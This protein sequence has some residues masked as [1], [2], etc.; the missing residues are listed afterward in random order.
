[1]EPLNPWTAIRKSMDALS[2]IAEAAAT[3]AIQPPAK[4]PHGHQ[5]SRHAF[6]EL[7]RGSRPPLVEFNEDLWLG[8]DRYGEEAGPMRGPAR[9]EAA[10]Y[11]AAAAG[12]NSTSGAAAIGSDEI[13]PLHPTP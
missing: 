2:V 3:E 4:R 6:Q 8:R 13:L 12:P 11:A 1:M 9:P 5:S 7:A 10:E